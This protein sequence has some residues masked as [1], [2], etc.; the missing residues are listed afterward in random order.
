[1]QSTPPCDQPRPIAPLRFDPGSRSRSLL[2]LFA[3]TL[4][5]MISVNAA[6]KDITWTGATNN[7]WDIVTS[8]WKL[9][10]GGTATT[11]AIGDTVT[12]DDS[13]SNGPTI[14]IN[15]GSGAAPGSVTMNNN[16]FTYTF[17][18]AAISGA[19]SFTMNGSGTVQ[20]NVA[21]SYGGG[22]F[23][24]N[25]TLRNGVTNGVPLNSTLT[26]GNLTNTTTFVL[27][28]G[29]GQQLGNIVIAPGAT[30]ADNTVTSTC[31]LYT[32]PSPRD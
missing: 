7:T 22:T 24:K 12:F 4:L 11:Y 8:N 16:N 6:A 27:S 23:L 30:A 1:M 15:M 14:S 32:S 29:V 25:G 2:K 13:A 26:M 9:T 31:L 19:G 20:F 3:V 17:T 18:N 28:V 5:A 21:N 10:V